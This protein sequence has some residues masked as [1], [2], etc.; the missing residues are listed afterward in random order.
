MALHDA[1][2]LN[3]HEHEICGILNTQIAYELE[4]LLLLAQR[5]SNK[6]A[7]TE[8]PPAAIELIRSNPL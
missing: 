3:I 8:Y 6:S 5:L 2:L 4:I 7:G 1:A